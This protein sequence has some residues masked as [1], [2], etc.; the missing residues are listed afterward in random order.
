MNYI[1]LLF[2]VIISGCNSSENL[3]IRKYYD[4]NSTE[5]GYVRK[6]NIINKRIELAHYENGI[7]KNKI[8]N[9]E[10]GIWCLEIN[11]S[12]IFFSNSSK[13]LVLNKLNILIE[14]PSDNFEFQIK[15]KWLLWFE[16]DFNCRYMDVDKILLNSNLYDTSTSQFNIEYAQQVLTEY[17]QDNN[18]VAYCQ[19]ANNWLKTGKHIPKY[20]EKLLSD[21]ITF[22]GMNFKEKT[23]ILKRVDDNFISIDNFNF[24]NE[25]IEEIINAFSQF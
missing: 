25:E 13:D 19:E 5:I 20:I 8:N 7:N 4:P 23:I 3:I 1:F 18:L 9:L 11:L 6:S 12:K 24:T 14:N 2:I 16:N 15:S 22:V 17:N 21:D 10:N